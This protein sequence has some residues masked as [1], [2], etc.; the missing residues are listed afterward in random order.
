MELELEEN[1]L[2]EYN[3]LLKNIL[4]NIND[5]IF[6]SNNINTPKNINDSLE[7]HSLI[8]DIDI[9]IKNINDI[10]NNLKINFNTIIDNNFI[11]RV[12]NKLNYIKIGLIKNRL[13]LSLISTV[14]LVKECNKKEIDNVNIIQTIE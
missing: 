8:K 12:E 6:I 14:M 9:K 1:N 13:T 3:K 2:F 7:Q 5:L 10:L 4:E 11:T